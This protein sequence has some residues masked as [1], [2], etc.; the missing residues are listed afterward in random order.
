MKQWFQ[1]IAGRILLETRACRSRTANAFTKAAP[2]P[3]GAHLPASEQQGR[4]RGGLVT[5]KH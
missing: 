4:Q 2:L 3:F 1:F 5:A